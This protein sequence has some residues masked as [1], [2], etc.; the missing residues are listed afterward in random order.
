MGSAA[1]VFMLLGA[2]TIWKIVQMNTFGANSSNPA[3]SQNRPQTDQVPAAFQAR[4]NVPIT[5]N[6]APPGPARGGVPLQPEG[7]AGGP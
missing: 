4:P 1:G 3:I 6:T 2:Y 7:A 5:P